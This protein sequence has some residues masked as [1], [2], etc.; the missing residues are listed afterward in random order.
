[1]RRRARR[2]TRTLGGHQRQVAQVA[3]AQ[4]VLERWRAR[5]LLPQCDVL[6]RAF[7]AWM[8]SGG[9]V[10]GSLNTSMTSSRMHALAS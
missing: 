2:H 8:I 1:M 6:G 10:A 7:T 5:R 3:S 9:F 4:P